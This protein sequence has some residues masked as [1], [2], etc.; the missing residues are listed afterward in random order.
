MKTRNPYA[1]ALKSAHLRKQVMADKTKANNRKAQ[2]SKLKSGKL[3]HFE[4][5]ARFIQLTNVS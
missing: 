2:R 5:F 3:V 1:R 4:Q